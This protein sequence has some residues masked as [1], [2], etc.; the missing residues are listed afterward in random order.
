MDIKKL[1]AVKLEALYETR[2]KA[3]R[4]LVDA[5]INAGRG[6]E[7]NQDIREAAKRGYDPLAFAYCS[8]LDAENEA[9]HEMDRRKRYH[10]TLKPIKQAA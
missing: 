4:D 1:S 6:H 3:V 10:G 5:M 2:D 8:A 9:R 7:T